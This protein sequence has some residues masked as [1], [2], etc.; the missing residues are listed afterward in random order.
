MKV[1]TADVIVLETVRRLVELQHGGRRAGGARRGGHVREGVD[2]EG[3]VGT[4]VMYAALGDPRRD[5]LSI[6]WRDW[7][8]S[9]EVKEG[10][11]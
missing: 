8:G 2:D 3:Q 5:C 7:T 9:L 1:P 6:V 11:Y 4:A 10:R